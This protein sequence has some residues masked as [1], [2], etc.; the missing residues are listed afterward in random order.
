MTVSAGERF[1]AGEGAVGSLRVRR[2]AF[3]RLPL[4]L[5]QA[6]L[7]VVSRQQQIE[8]RHDEQREQRADRQAARNHQ[9]GPD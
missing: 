3:H 4:F 6:R 9:G 1:I 2:N 7:G 8:G 5:L